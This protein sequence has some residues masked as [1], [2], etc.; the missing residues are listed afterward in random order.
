MKSLTSRQKEVV[1]YLQN[2]IGAHKYPP[3]VRELASYL[4]VTP[5]G[6]YDHLRALEKKGWI[7]SCLNRCRAIEILLDETGRPFSQEEPEFIRIPILGRVAAG[8]PLFA[9]ENLEGY[10]KIHPDDMR[11]GKY[12]ALMVKGDSMQNAGI[13]DGDTAII[14]Q[15]NTANNGDIVVACLDEEAVTLKRFYKEKQWVNLKAENPSHHTIR[16][17]NVRI[18]GKLKRIIRQYG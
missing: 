4:G 13:L 8:T 3:T 11:P 14:L 5:R 12:F 18:L 17:Q 1:V 9:E 6:A 2:F 7:R 15:Q 16:S 10:L